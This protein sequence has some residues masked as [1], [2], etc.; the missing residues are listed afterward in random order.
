MLPPVLEIAPESGGRIVFGGADAPTVP[1]RT[2]DP[3]QHPPKETQVFQVLQG[4]QGVCLVALPQVS[5]R[6]FAAL[7][8]PNPDNCHDP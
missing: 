4:R 2:V 1:G 7:F 5:A 3:G 6:A 8:H